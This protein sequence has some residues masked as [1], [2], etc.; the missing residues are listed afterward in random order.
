M[1]KKNKKK[2]FVSFYQYD[3]D[4]P[5]IIGFDSIEE[6]RKEAKKDIRQALPNRKDWKEYL[7]TFEKNGYVA[8]DDIL[9]S[10]REVKYHPSI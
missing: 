2:L 3:M 10:A 8:I 9:I 7:G 4:D 5:V 1:K 6:A